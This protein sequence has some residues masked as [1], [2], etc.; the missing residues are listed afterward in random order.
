MNGGS[1]QRSY[2]IYGHPYSQIGEPVGVT[3]RV[4]QPHESR[5]NVPKWEKN[6]HRAVQVVIYLKW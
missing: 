5:K 4:S 3:I 2:G 6:Q 1:E